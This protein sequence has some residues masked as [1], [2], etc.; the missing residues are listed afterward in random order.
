MPTQE[1]F[2]K[3]LNAVLT[4]VVN[5]R[6]EPIPSLETEYKDTGIDSLDGLLLGMY[7]TDIYGLPE[8]VLKDWHPTSFIE[9]YEHI[10]KHKTRIPVSVEEA[11][12][13]VE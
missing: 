8:E 1:E 3:I 6:L 13:L 11:L 9:M 7:M 2:L 10:V 5:K 4:K 12:A